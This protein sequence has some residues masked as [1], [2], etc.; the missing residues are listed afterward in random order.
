MVEPAQNRS[1][2]N[3]TVAGLRLRNRCLQAEA[4]VRTIM[5]VDPAEMT[6]VDENQMVE[7]LPTDCPHPAFGDRVRAG[8][9]NRGPQTL[10]NKPALPPGLIA[11][12]PRDNGRCRVAGARLER[13]RNHPLESK[14]VPTSARAIP[15]SWRRL[16]FSLS[17]VIPSRP[18]TA[19]LVATKGTTMAAGPDASASR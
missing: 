19:G 5:V 9:P 7:A 3:P 18:A 2:S 14:T 11:L 15:A 13:I 1:D 16:V 12:G 6:F 8:R 17:R 10:D 4:A